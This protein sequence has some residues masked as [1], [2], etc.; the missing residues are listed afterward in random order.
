MAL[1]ISLES[2]GPGR[3]RLLVS[4]GRPAPESTS[5]AIQRNDGRYLAPG[6]LW[7]VT[8]HWHPQFSVEPMADGIRLELG[9]DLVDGI[10][11]VGGAPLRVA[12]RI[13]GVED[14]AVLRIRGELVG[15]GATAPERSAFDS[16]DTLIMPRRSESGRVEA[17]DLSDPASKG[18]SAPAAETPASNRRPLWPWIAAAIVL[19][20]VAGGVGVWQFGWLGP[21][22]LDES[23][24]AVTD[25]EIDPEPVPD[26]GP[27]ADV[28][29]EPEPEQTGL[30]LA[31]KFLAGDPAAEAVFA[32]AE[33]AEEAGDCPAAYALYSEAANKDPGLAARLARRYDPLT[34]TAGPC[35]AAPDAPYATVYY[36]DA[37]EAGDVAVQRRL[38]Q[39]MVERESS[40]PT[41]E[42]GVA[43]LRRA[44]EAGDEDAKRALDG[45]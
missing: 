9:P 6:Q 7:Q 25:A 37:A 8:S 33:Q 42:A 44:A 29:L 35:I 22:A 31:R 15:S 30:L 12:L 11:G 1:T 21:D 41:R 16:G 23:A 2:I 27:P 40:G 17:E 4:G 28:E 20:L 10:I 38:G 5:L 34:H 36:A 24:E 26:D 3:G 18:P 45:L 19:V 32:R 43:W 14:A 39:L 13:D